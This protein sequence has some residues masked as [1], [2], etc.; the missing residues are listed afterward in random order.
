MCVCVC[1]F[2]VMSPTVTNFHY[3]VV[4]HKTYIPSQQSIAMTRGPAVPH[5]INLWTILQHS[6]YFQIPPILNLRPSML[7]VHM[8]CSLKTDFTVTACIRYWARIANAWAFNSFK[9][10][11]HDGPAPVLLHYLPEYLLQTVGFSIT[12]KRSIIEKK[13]DRESYKHCIS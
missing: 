3:M 11:W 2:F 5:R 1:L 13:V 9:S 12:M 10:S 6:T 8:K 4:I 7:K